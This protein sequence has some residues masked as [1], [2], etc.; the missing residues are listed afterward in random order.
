MLTIYNKIEKSLNDTSGFQIITN[1]EYLNR[2]FLLCLTTQNNL[3]KSIYGMMR[4]GAQAARVLTTQ[5]IAGGF[6]IN[7]FPIDILG[8]RHQNDD[9]SE[10]Y[11]EIAEQ[12]LYPYLT[13]SGTQYEN[14]ITQASKVNILAFCDAVDLYAKVEDRLATLLQKD[15]FLFEQVQTILSR[16]CMIAVESS[17]ETGRLYATSVAFM[18]VCD[19]K[20]AILNRESYLD[21]LEMQKKEFMY[22]PLGKSNSVLYIFKG[23]G[24]HSIKEFLSSKSS[25]KP[26][27]CA[28]TSFF[29]EKSLEASPVSV[30]MIMDCINQYSLDTSIEERLQQLDHQLSYQN[31][32]RYSKESADLRMELNMVYHIL[33]K[34]NERFIR[35]LEK[36]QAQN[37]RL[38]SII[39]GIHEFSSD[40]TFQQVLTYAN[41]WKK[42]DGEN[43]LSIPSDK[44]I[45]VTVLN[46]NVTEDD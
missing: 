15:G 24:K 21:A 22:S 8:V 9:D 10:D 4:E 39:Y 29:L 35:T 42:K 23:Y 3:T 11:L 20:L 19:S 37:D 25:V 17:Y 27:F 14:V 43:L 34:T 41:M 33:K 16:I 1:V 13:R 46:E 31:A 5:E 28:V 38:N 32:P 36:K 12:F 40:V 44:Q 30:S 2:P 26:V 45:R 18:D 7:D 6:K